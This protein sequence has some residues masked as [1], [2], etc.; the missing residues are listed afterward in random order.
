[1]RRLI[2]IILFS[3]LG[4]VAA[5][6]QKDTTN[7]SAKDSVPYVNNAFEPD[8]YLK[9]KVKYGIISGGYAELKIGMEQ[10]GYDWF[11]RAQAI[12]RTTGAVGALAKVSDRYESYFDLYSGLPL[13]AIRDINESNYHVY[14]EVIFARDEN[15]V[16]SLKSGEH[17]VPKGILDILSAFYYARRVVFDKQIQKK[18]VINLTTFFDDEIYKIKI[19]FLKQERVRTKF[20][21]INSLKFVPVV[22]SKSSFKKESDLQ[23][24]FS[25]DGNF[26]PLKIRLKLGISK[27]KCDLTA[28]DNLKNPLGKPFERNPK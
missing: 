19:R 4:F 20:G 10:I 16:I 18:D 13:L 7:V 21:K 2:F 23:I 22:D 28:Y 11:Y 9:Y 15:K 26:I 5:I 25:D 8:E 24:W 1:M 27:V 14:N 6:A 17:K 3:A 12:A